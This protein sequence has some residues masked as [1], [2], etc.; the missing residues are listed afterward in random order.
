MNSGELEEDVSRP[1]TEPDSNRYNSSQR[2]QHEKY[3]AQHKHNRGG[4][5]CNRLKQMTKSC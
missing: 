2:I 3:E 4:E 1:H 5:K